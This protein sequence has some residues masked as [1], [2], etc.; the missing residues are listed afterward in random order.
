MSEVVSEKPSFYA[1]IPS[2]VRYDE[3]LSSTAKL[4]Y[5]EITALANS[6]GYCFASNDYFV[7]LYKISKRQIITLIKKLEQANY[8][9][10]EYEK[11]QRKIYLQNDYGVKKSSSEG[12]KKFTQRGEEKFTH[13][14]TSIN[15]KNNN[16]YNDNNKINNIYKELSS[17]VVCYE[18]NI[19][20][21]TQ[22]VRDS[23][24][25]WL[26]DVDSD[27]IIWAINEAVK[28]NK[29]NWKY[30]E[31]ILRNQFNK[32]N[33]TMA[34]ITAS[35]KERGNNTKSNSYTSNNNAYD[36]DGIE[37][38]MWAN[39]KNENTK[40]DDYSDLFKKFELG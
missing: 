37:K 31:G 11:N 14:N 7:Q 3:D 40:H 17:V 36:F 6:K 18:N 34:K 5:A 1:V 29:R 30:I 39:L 25:D 13:N 32:G 28:L 12:E 19:S 22:I 35:E 10:V 27:V 8:I 15:N 24:I 16:I 33:T 2:D 9:K 26:N 4:L 21:I 20:P 23:M 38:Q